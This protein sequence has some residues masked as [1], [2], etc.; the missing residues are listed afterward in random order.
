MSALFSEAMETQHYFKSSFR[1]ESVKILSVLLCARLRCLRCAACAA[2][3]RRALCGDANCADIEELHYAGCGL[4]PP[5]QLL[6][7]L[8]LFYPQSRRCATVGL[9]WSLFPRSGDKHPE[10][11]HL[12]V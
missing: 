7:K 12:I 3:R 4:R 2:H 10:S 5:V 6:T 8:I 11:G 9:I 1:V